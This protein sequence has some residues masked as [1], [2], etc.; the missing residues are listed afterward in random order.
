MENCLIKNPYSI[1]LID[2]NGNVL[3]TYIYYGDVPAKIRA[4]ILNNNASVLKQFYDRD[5]VV[6]GGD[7]TELNDLNDLSIVINSADLEVNDKPIENIA[8][9]IAPAESQMSPI[10]YTAGATTPI[11]DISIYPEDTI[12][13]VKE[14]IFLT[15]GVPVYRQHITWGQLPYIISTPEGPLGVDIRE[16]TS[17]D[18]IFGIPVDKNLYKMRASLKV[19]AMDRFLC[20]YKL[21]SR[22]LYLADLSQIIAPVSPQI[23][24][25]INDAYTIDLFYWGFVFKYFPMLTRE[26]FDLYIRNENEILVKY[27]MI[28]SSRRILQNVYQKEKL[29]IDNN[30]RTAKFITKMAQSKNLGT[31]IINIIVSV[32]DTM[33]RQINIRG[34]VDK[35]KLSAQM[36]YI[37]AFIKHN[38]LYKIEKSY[39][40]WTN[41]AQ[42]SQMFRQ[43]IM[44]CLKH[45]ATK[46]VYF[47]ILTTGRMLIKFEWN[48]E[49]KIYFDDVLTL[50][51]SRINPIIQTIN[52]LGRYARI[53]G[54]PLTLINRQNI[55]YYNID[56]C[57]YWKRA[58]SIDVFN[59][60]KRFLNEYDRARI[61]ETKTTHAANSYEFIFRK[62]MTE[63]DIHAFERAVMISGLDS[64]RNGYNYLINPQLNQKWKQLYSGRTVRMIHRTADIKFEISSIKEYEYFIFYNYLLAFIISASCDKQFSC[65]QST[66]APVKKLK[67]LQETDPDLFNLKKYGSK[68]IYSVK[69]QNPK[70]PTVYSDYELSNLSEAKKRALV[71]YWNFTTNRPNYYACENPQYRKL[72]FLT[73]IHPKDFCIP[74]CGIDYMPS[75][76]DVIDS[77]CLQKHILSRDDVSAIVKPDKYKKKY[78]LSY[79]GIIDAGKIYKL[80]EMLKK[81]FDPP[82]YILGVER[83]APGGLINSFA[84]LIGE[85]PSA[86]LKLIKKHIDAA[87]IDLSP[88]FIKYETSQEAYL[89]NIE[90]FNDVSVE[91][92]E[93][94]LDYAFI[95]CEGQDTITIKTSAQVLEKSAIGAAALK[96]IILHKNKTY[97]NPI[98]Q[99][100][101]R[102]L[103][104]NDPAVV[105]LLDIIRSMSHNVSA[106]I[107]LSI[108]RKWRAPTGKFVNFRNQ[109]FAVEFGD[110]ILP[111]N[112]SLNISD[113]I[114]I[115]PLYYS[116]VDMN[117]ATKLVAELNEFLVKNGRR[118]MIIMNSLWYGAMFIGLA[119]SLGIIYCSGTQPGRALSYDPREI[120]TLLLSDHKTESHGRER[121]ELTINGIYSN[122]IYQLLLLEFVNKISMER[123]EL[124]RTK[125]INSIKEQNNIHNL[126][127]ELNDDDY[128][129]IN[130]IINEN[131]MDKKSL[132]TAFAACS[133]EFDRMT[134]MKIL[135]AQDGGRSILSSALSDL[136]IIRPIPKLST[137]SN[138]YLP[139]SLQKNDYCDGAKLIIDEARTTVS[140]EKFIDILLMDIKNAIKLK[141]MFSGAFEDNIVEYFNFDKRL[142]EE[143]KITE[144]QK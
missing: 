63:Y 12:A 65:T 56:I 78:I 132:V 37:V 143:I 67:K 108:M 31:S 49:D 122:N 120:N 97:I 138:I 74:C 34:L 50:I 60:L 100:E 127:D 45:S 126:K 51:K 99:T 93:T 10:S 35:L 61:I 133:Y 104:N 79:K 69:C 22:V 36:P 98:I 90:A 27:P 77:E 68:I 110:V 88:I 16:H 84:A 71:K 2:L 4:A 92:L 55:V 118:A 130:Q 137:F 30:Y 24:S 6:C 19:T 119:T 33:P 81:L 102:I 76:R 89:A 21:P 28:Q 14:K 83:S 112:E 134:V 124:L 85:T 91:I 32:R 40:G 107:D 115:K 9:A 43:G 57:L 38:K 75:H 20:V 111:C 87:A 1:K 86:A 66:I 73:G 142:T 96:F 80:P 101:P 109:I 41:D 121:E 136:V 103:K 58:V 131:A 113:N 114:P 26:L 62:G 94:L 17:S 25:S 29:I 18:N 42:I 72:M 140:F 95:I 15:V 47:N 46:Y 141:Y 3:H 144:V 11:F 125:I 5:D 7:S 39:R 105:L 13:D 59:I 48:E 52:D 64:A 8:A 53:T 116:K 106:I 123:N 23:K 139:C 135:S 82:M 54:E 70:Q 129:A 44:L 117:A 128:A